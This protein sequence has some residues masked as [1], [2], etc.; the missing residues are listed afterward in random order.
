MYSLQSLRD[1]SNKS[2][3][4]PCL[5]SNLHIMHSMN[6]FENIAFFLQSSI[7]C[8]F[9]PCWKF[10]SISRPIISGFIQS[11][12]VHQGLGRQNGKMSLWAMALKSYRPFIKTLGQYK[13]VTTSES[14]SVS[15]LSLS[16]AYYLTNYGLQNILKS[17]NCVIENRKHL[18]WVRTLFAS[19]VRV[20]GLGT[21]P[22]LTLL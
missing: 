18:D 11:C 17:A 9:F 5:F 15:K 16:E 10:S 19:I 2:Q 22:K 12:I 13:T 21:K 14:L 3:I 6:L 7:F 4:W 8:L 20:R 1:H